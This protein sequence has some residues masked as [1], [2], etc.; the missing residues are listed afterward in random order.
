MR[1]PHLALC[2]LAMAASGLMPG[3]SHAQSGKPEASP[4]AFSTRTYS[5]PSHELVTGFVSKD[6]GKLRAPALPP[7]SA[8]HG[9]QEAFLKRSHEVLKEYLAIQGAPL[10]PGSLACYDPA[11]YT[12]S[13]RAM[14]AVQDMV[15]SLSSTLTS[16]ASKHVSWR[17]EVVEAPSAD[18][19]AMV[20]QCQGKVEHGKQLDAITS[21]GSSIITMRGETKGGQQISSRQGSSFN[22]PTE[23]ATGASG[24][25]ESSIA[26][27]YSGVNFELDSVIG[28]NG[29]LDINCLFQYWPSPPKPRL[30]TLSAGSAPKTEAEWL[31]L[32]ACSAKFSSTYRSGQTR[33]LGVWDMET[34][35]LADPAKAGRSQAAFLCAHI[36]NLLP[37]PESRVEAMLRER[38]EAVLATPK[39]VRPVAD[40]TLPP[41]MM[42]R[43]FRVPPDFD[44]MGGPAAAA[45]A[46]ADPFASGAAPVNEPRFVRNVTVEDILKSQGIPFPTGASANFLRTTNELVVRNLPENLDLVQTFIDEISAGV[47]KL[48]QFTVEIVEADAGLIR[49]LNREAEALPDHSAAQKALEAEIAAGRAR[50]VKT[51]WIETK[52][53]QQATCENV[54][55]TQDAFEF[56]ARAEAPPPPAKK[57]GEPAPAEPAAKATPAP[58]SVVG[59]DVA[60]GCRVEVDPVI[61]ENGI[62]DL[63]IFVNA[64]TAPLGT[65]AAAA[66]PEPGIQRLASVNSVRR[67]MVFKTSVSMQNGIPRLLSVYQPAQAEGQA[68]NVLHAVIVRGDIAELDGK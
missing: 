51:V 33:L 16:Q 38:G 24:H 13:L 34:L 6:K 18:V 68:A 35:A 55:Q 7:P 40:P 15:E 64:D 43:R 67:G 45:P 10:A 66:A 56:G 62:L 30:A 50:V 46:A 23:Y 47:T 58:L 29:S 11:T 21:K 14:N 26:E 42:V 60:I 32:T 54:V 25:V 41:G 2:A 37:L 5:L 53:G 39:G 17:L 8:S 65:L 22:R 20:A 44:S 4:Y 52:G 3:T 31:D 57:E 19:R 1:S 49:R 63:N 28:D 48:S 9:E 61:G 12:L 27:A 36:V 59:E